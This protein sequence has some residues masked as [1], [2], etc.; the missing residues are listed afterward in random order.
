MANEDEQDGQGSRPGL[1]QAIGHG[2]LCRCPRCGK[3]KLMTGFLTQVATCANCGEPLGH[4]NVGLLLP[5]VVIMI[6]AHMLIFAMLQMELVGWANPGL[7]MAVLVP[8]SIVAPLA[9][10]RPVKGGLIGLLWRL[11]ASDELDR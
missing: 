7:Y 3:G 9:I 4:L 11:R 1:W 10:I 6:V 2:L 8:L 5:F